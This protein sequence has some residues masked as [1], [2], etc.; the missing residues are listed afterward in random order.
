MKVVILLAAV[1]AV[2]AITGPQP[3]FPNDWQAYERDALAAFQGAV[4]HVGNLMCCDPQSTCEVQ[5]QYQ[6]GNV[7]YDYSHNRT[8]FDDV[9]ERQTI[10]TM[11]DIQ[12]EMLVVNQTCK[13]FCPLD[14]DRM[15]PGFLD[16]NATDLG[17]TTLPPPDGRKCEHWQ[18]KETIF[19]II[20]MEVCDV[21]INQTDMANA[22]PFGEVDHLTP[23]GQHIGDFTSNWEQF[24]PGTPDPSLFIVNGIDSC[25][26][27]PNCGEQSLQ[28]NRLRNGAM[29][30]WLRW[31]QNNLLA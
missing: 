27:S 24:K 2:A 30:T 3:K 16:V 10:I 4:K 26:E 19:G 13:E 11:F 8:R 15:H 6:A 28:F 18:W 21:Y 12:K 17:Q 20:V 5:T 23:F 9:A 14:G 7:Y 22:V 31:H 1:V 29:K 25:P